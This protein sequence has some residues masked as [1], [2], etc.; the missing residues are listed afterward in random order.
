MIPLLL[1]LL[2]RGA[3]GAGDSTLFFAFPNFLAAW[4]AEHCVT[5]LTPD[6]GCP[7]PFLSIELQGDF[8][9]AATPSNVHAFAWPLAAP[10]TC[11]TPLLADDP[12]RALRA[13]RVDSAMLYL[14][15]ARAG[16]AGGIFSVPLPARLPPQA[17]PEP[18][19][20][21]ASK[22]LNITSLTVG[23]ELL[24]FGFEGP[25]GTGV[26]QLTL[27]SPSL[28]VPVFTYPLVQQWVVTD[29]DGPLYAGPGGALNL[30]WSEWRTSGDGLGT[31]NLQLAN[32][33][34]R[35]L[36]TTLTY[37]G[38]D[39][40]PA[41]ALGGSLA[42]DA[43]AGALL[44]ASEDSTSAAAFSAWARGTAP[45]NYVFLQWAA[46]GWGAVSDV[47]L[48][49]EAGAAGAGCRI[50]YA[51]YPTTP[52]P[53]L[54]DVPLPGCGAT[55]PGA[56]VTAQP[57]ATPGLTPTAAPLPGGGGG[58]GGQEGLSTGGAV[59]LTA[60]CAGL[61]G[62]AGALWLQQQHQTRAARAAARA[63]AAEEGER[64]R[65]ASLE[66]KE[67]LIAPEIVVRPRL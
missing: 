17:L 11:G 27:S 2:S 12:H 5:F 38:S 51:Q 66:E 45:N 37:L 49:R 40:A 44:F 35:A 19:L 30:W 6:A 15:D 61:G 59:A 20:V 23:S 50:P 22:E 41:G 43:E 16:G 63:A 67:Q 24:F 13:A 55:P 39:G 56:S 31:A 18:T 8:V 48:A 65:R 57:S 10:A 60:V 36:D 46:L 9:Y 4:D 58:G 25:N 28:V 64:K 29:L 53:L 3:S 14:A 47:S 21:F 54:C 62:A 7:G 34:G 33:S 26:S 32:F 42:V 52:A 1:L